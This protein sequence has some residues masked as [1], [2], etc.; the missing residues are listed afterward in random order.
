MLDK[1]KKELLPLDND[2]VD[3][4][5]DLIE[6]EKV[7]EMNDFIQHGGTSCL[8]HCFN[9]SYSSYYLCKKAG[10]D[11]RSAAR[12]GLL[13][14][15]FLYD[16]RVDK[17]SY[18]GFHGFAHPK[19]ALKNATELFDLNEKEKN[20]ILRHMWPL[21]I[22]PSKYPETYIVTLADKYCAVMEFFNY[23]NKRKQNQIKKL[24]T[25]LNVTNI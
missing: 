24:Y 2:Y 7:L 15:F 17:D 6:N 22:T 13:H 1:I 19:I 11:Y 14:D 8:K 18:T 12:G 5:T 10:L 25:L 4:I 3:C 21:T 20:I 16:W 9:V 23:E